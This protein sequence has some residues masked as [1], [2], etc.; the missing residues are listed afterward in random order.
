LV[1]RQH[2]A[3]FTQEKQKV[4]P[5]AAILLDLAEQIK[6]WTKQGDQVI[7]MMDEDVNE[8][9]RKL[10]IQPFLSELGMREVL[11]EK[12]GASVAPRTHLRGSAPID[13]ISGYH[14]WRLCS[15]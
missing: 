8:D 3:H 15:I 10:T 1:Y 6:E 13:C 2:W 9:V 12:H 11:H 5:W 4:D 14:C 7:M